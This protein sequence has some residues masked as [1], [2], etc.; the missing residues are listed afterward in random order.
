MN[1]M[2]IFNETRWCNNQKIPKWSLHCLG[3]GRRGYIGC[4]SKSDKESVVNFLMRQDG[5]MAIYDIQ[6]SQR[7]S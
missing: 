1:Q 4:L 3:N 7:C 6:L 5:V 2:L